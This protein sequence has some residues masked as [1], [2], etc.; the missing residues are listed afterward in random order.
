[1]KQASYTNIHVLQ[2]IHILY[3]TNLSTSTDPSDTGY[4]STKIRT[5]GYD[6]E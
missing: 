2:N 6:I 1:M 4:A 5:E 3:T